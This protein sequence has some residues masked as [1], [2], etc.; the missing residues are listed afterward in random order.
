M[1]VKKIISRLKDEIK[2]VSLKLEWRKKN[3]HNYTVIGNRFNQNHVKVGYGTY[4]MINVVFNWLS[5]G[6]SAIGGFV[7]ELVN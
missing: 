7:W 2:F 6:L 5:G 1:L 4:G 3:R